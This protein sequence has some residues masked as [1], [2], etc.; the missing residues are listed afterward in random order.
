[1]PAVSALALVSVSFLVIFIQC[2]F[3]AAN[4]AVIF[5]GISTRAGSLR[6]DA[7][8]LEVEKLDASFRISSPLIDKSI[9]KGS[10]AYA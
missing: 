6:M 3:L 4:L 2:S 9:S 5:S 1:V 8:W 7:C 10:I